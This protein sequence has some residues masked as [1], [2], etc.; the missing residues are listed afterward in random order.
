MPCFLIR[1]T[2]FHCPREIFQGQPKNSSSDGQG[3]FRPRPR[4]GSCCTS[5]HRPH[6]GAQAGSA[7]SRRFSALFPASFDPDQCPDRQCR[8]VLLEETKVHDAGRLLN[9]ACCAPE[10]RR[11]AERLQV[12]TVGEHGRGMDANCAAAR[13][14]AR[15]GGDC[16]GFR[17]ASVQGAQETGRLHRYIAETAPAS[18]KS[19][20]LNSIAA[21]VSCASAN[22][23]QSPK[24]SCAGWPVPLPKSR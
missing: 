18:A 20:P 9:S 17:N 7:R 3:S 5:Q 8:R 15:G 1:S 12:R 21:P 16:A 4:Y 23:K 19:R 10:L 14:C 24:F 11:P 2:R 13:V 22:T 6:T